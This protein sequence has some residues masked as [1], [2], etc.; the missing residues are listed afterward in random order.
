MK[1]NQISS[2]KVFLIINIVLMKCMFG[3]LYVTLLYINIKV[4]MAVNISF[5]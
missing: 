1:Q 2:L 5:L 4:F 3:Q